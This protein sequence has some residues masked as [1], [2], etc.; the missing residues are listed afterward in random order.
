MEQIQSGLTRLKL[1]GMTACLKTLEETGWT[2]E[3][4]FTDGLTLLMQAETDLGEA[5]L[6]RLKLPDMTVSP[7]AQEEATSEHESPFTGVLKRL[8]RAEAGT[9]GISH[10][11]RI[12]KQGASHKKAYGNESSLNVIFINL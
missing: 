12:I 2:H 3:P 1:S 6:T 5:S 9:K 11:E 4:T 7:V 10:F 8:K